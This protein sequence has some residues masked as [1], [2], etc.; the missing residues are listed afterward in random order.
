MAAIER[1]FQAVP[2]PDESDNI[3]IAASDDRQSAVEAYL[4]SGVDVNAQDDMGYSPLYA[5]SAPPPPPPDYFPSNVGVAGWP[6]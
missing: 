4:S 5:S 1:P 3:W 2:N 6:Q